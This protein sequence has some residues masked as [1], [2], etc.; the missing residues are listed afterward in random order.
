MSLFYFD[1]KL[2]SYESSFQWDQALEYLQDLFVHNDSIPLLNSLV[3]FSWLYLTEGPVISQKFEDDPSVLP[4]AV[5]K[6]Y[7][8]FGILTASSNPYFNFIAGYTLSLSG[9]YI[10]SEYESMGTTLMMKCSHLAGD[11]P[12]KELADYFLINEESTKYIPLTNGKA[13]CQKLFGGKS[14]LDRYFSELYFD[15]SVYPRN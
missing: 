5:W 7:I 3:G 2:E 9:L 6:K 4:L 15:E 14:L 10:S 8:D 12:L 1:D 11:K 13:I